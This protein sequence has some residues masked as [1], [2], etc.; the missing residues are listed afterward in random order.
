MVPTQATGNLN[1]QG[2]VVQQTPGVGYTANSARAQQLAGIPNTATPQP[3][4][5][6]QINYANQ[7]G[8]PLAQAQSQQA[9]LQADT[10]RSKALAGAAPAQAEADIAQ[11]RAQ[12][13]IQNYVADAVNRKD[14]TALARLFSGGNPT[15][16]ATGWFS[17]ADQLQA[18]GADPA[19]VNSVRNRGRMAA[20]GQPVPIGPQDMQWLQAAVAWLGQFGQW[21]GFG[22]GQQPAAPAPGR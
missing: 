5:R 3:D 14:A 6:T 20:G 11:S 10:A 22:G 7:T 2:N 19:T 4:A 21:M 12:G 13:A 16:V 18:K 17:L 1:M 8:I 15:E 9:G